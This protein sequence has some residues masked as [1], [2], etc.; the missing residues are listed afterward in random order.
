[1]TR[2]S[3]DAPPSGYPRLSPFG[4]VSPDIPRLELP[5]HGPLSRGITG[6]QHSRGGAIGQRPVQ[7]LP[8]RQQPGKEETPQLLPEVALVAFLRQ[9]LLKQPAAVLLHLVNQERQHHQVRQ[10][11]REVL[12]TMTEVMLKVVALVLQGI[13]RLIPNLPARPRPA[14]QP[15]QI[16][17]V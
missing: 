2:L 13:E 5:G 16:V 3:G 15:H 10:H 9:R 4:L 6:C 17:L 12:V 7:H 11:R 1:M 8:I 14:H